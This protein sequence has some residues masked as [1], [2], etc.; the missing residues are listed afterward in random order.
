MYTVSGDIVADGMREIGWDGHFPIGET[1][2]DQLAVPGQLPSWLTADD[3]AVLR[4]RSLAAAAF[5]AA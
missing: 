1:V 5:E 3:L 2:T 4:R